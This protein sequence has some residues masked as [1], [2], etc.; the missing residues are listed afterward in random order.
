MTVVKQMLLQL[1]LFNPPETIYWIFKLHAS[2]YELM[3]CYNMITLLKTPE[4]ALNCFLLFSFFTKEMSQ[5]LKE[6]MIIL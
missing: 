4:P 2:L 6:E 5:K 3:L 1:E